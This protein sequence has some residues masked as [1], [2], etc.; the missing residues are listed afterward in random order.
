MTASTNNYKYLAT[1]SSEINYFVQVH[2]R[3]NK[4][5]P[6]SHKSMVNFIIVLGINEMSQKLKERGVC[7]ALP[8]SVC[9]ARFNTAEFV[10]LRSINKL[11]WVMI[12]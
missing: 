5:K 11:D 6:R 7:N 1:N 10:T 3:V 12:S 8:G 9:L 4:I 2:N